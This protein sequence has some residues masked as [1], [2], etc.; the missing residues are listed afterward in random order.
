MAED[1]IIYSTREFGF[2]SLSEAYRYA[3]SLLYYGTTRQGRG[4][5]WDVV[6]TFSPFIYNVYLCSHVK[7][8]SNRAQIKLLI[9]LFFGFSL[10]R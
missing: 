1:L 2:V 9:T 4:G 10:V 3:L 6:G 7:L 5:W 8:N